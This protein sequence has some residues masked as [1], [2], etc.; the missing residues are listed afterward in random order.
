[1]DATPFRSR[2]LRPSP[3]RSTAKAANEDSAEDATRPS[4]SDLRRRYDQNRNHVTTPERPSSRSPP[5]V[6]VV[7]SKPPRGVIKSPSPPPAAVARR[8]VAELSGSSDS[9]ESGSRTPVNAKKTSP[10]PDREDTQNPPAALPSRWS[11]ENQLRSSSPSTL[12][13][14]SSSDGEAQ[15]KFLTALCALTRERDPFHSCLIWQ[16]CVITT[17]PPSRMGA[18][19]TGNPDAAIKYLARFNGLSNRD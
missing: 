2:F 9:E 16:T 3:D 13:S 1:M 14:T 4:V 5:P 15:V 17:G 10:T 12:S 19:R 11:K 6:V 8:A 18:G 7:T